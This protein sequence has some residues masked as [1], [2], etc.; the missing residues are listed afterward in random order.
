MQSLASLPAHL[1]AGSDGRDAAAMLRERGATHVVLH[2][3]AWLSPDEPAAV[4]T[5]LTRL[6]ATR[7][8]NVG[9]SEI[10]TFGPSPEP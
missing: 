4:R 1:L 8:A 6:G 9:R 2:A 5:W 7:V 3:G 10:W